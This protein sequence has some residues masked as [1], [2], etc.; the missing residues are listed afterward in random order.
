VSALATILLVV[1]V[2][3]PVNAEEGVNRDDVAFGAATPVS[4]EGLAEVHGTGVPPTN[5]LLRND[6]AVILWDE[7][8]KVKPTQTST[9]GANSSQTQHTSIRVR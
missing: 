2:A 5:P 4:D 3:G 7:Q 6:V 8:P 1:A 9:E